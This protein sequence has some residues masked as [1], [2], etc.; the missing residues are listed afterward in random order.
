MNNILRHLKIV[1][2]QSEKTLTFEQFLQNYD[3]QHF[4][5]TH[6]EFYKDYYLSKHF[7]EIYNLPDSCDYD[8]YE[9]F[10]LFEIIGQ[11]YEDFLTDLGRDGAYKW[12]NPTWFS[13]Y[14]EKHEE[15]SYDEVD[16]L[17]GLKDDENLLNDDYYDRVDKMFGES[18]S[19]WGYN[20]FLGALISEYELFMS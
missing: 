9:H 5:E 12:L 17:I 7:I 19:V 18:W 2:T 6:Q 20:E 11:K 3:P 8:L 13:N 10:D 4:V 14:S 1:Q 15:F 16:F